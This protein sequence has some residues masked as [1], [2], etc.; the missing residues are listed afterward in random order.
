MILGSLWD[1]F[2]VFHGHFGFILR[3]SR[4]ILRCF[5]G[6]LAFKKHVFV[7]KWVGKARNPEILIPID[8]A[9]AGD[10]ENHGFGKNPRKPKIV[11]FP[12]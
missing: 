11:L 6:L 2:G 10:L 4:V 3:S 5:E 1:D 12:N 7:T 8:A 9:W